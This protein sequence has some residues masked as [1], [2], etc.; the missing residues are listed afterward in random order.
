ML[1][2]I[3]L[4][5]IVG[6]LGAVA[7]AA[8]L[9]SIYQTLAQGKSPT[10]LVASVLALPAFYG[11]GT[12]AR[13]LFIPHDAVQKGGGVYLLMILLALI[14]IDAVP[15]FRLIRWVSR[16]IGAPAP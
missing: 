3:V 2:S 11:G 10:A 14:V 1:A 7:L 12:W 13:S 15:C 5:L 4:G 16:T 8:T 9:D 6:L